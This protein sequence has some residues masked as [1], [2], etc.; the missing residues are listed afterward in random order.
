MYNT[1]IIRNSKTGVDGLVGPQMNNESLS[2]ICAL[3]PSIDTRRMH[4][5]DLMMPET[6]LSISFSQRNRRKLVDT[7]HPCSQLVPTLTLGPQAQDSINVSSSPTITTQNPTTIPT[8]QHSPPSPP[9][10][11]SSTSTAHAQP[12]PS[13]KHHEF[14]SSGNTILN[15]GGRITEVLQLNGRAADYD[16]RIR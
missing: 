2:A 9:S 16:R 13:K 6:F 5:F 14:G 4:H 3:S 11:Y 7:G 8:H 15:T 1:T 10:D 12:T